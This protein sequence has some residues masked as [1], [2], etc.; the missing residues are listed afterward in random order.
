MQ[1]AGILLLAFAMVAVPAR[2]ALVCRRRGQAFPRHRLALAA[3]A[4]AITLG[5]LLGLDAAADSMLS[6]HM[7]QHML[8]GDL[9]PLLLV[10]AFRPPVLGHALAFATRP[11]LAFAF[12]AC[13]IALWH[14]PAAYDRALENEQLHAF[15]HATFM[16]AGLL[17][18]TALLDPAGRGTLPGWR[19]FGYA[20]ALLVASGALANT[21]ILSYRPLYPSYADAAH[22]PLGLTPIGDQDLAALT[23]MLEQL[24]TVGTF[25]FLCARRQLAAPVERPERHP[26][27]A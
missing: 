23:M 17:V 10:L 14:I 7:L 20:L 15:E 5:A 6:A 19:R 18:W 11:V 25:A 4:A 1:T 3:L 21:L 8:I 16:L 12:W 27:A 9:V 13:A 24:L 2:A 22:R 26:L